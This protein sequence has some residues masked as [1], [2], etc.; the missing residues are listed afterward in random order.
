MRMA[1]GHLIRICRVANPTDLLPLFWTLNSSN[2]ELAAWGEFIGGIAVV[3]G[4]FFVGIQL[5][6]ANR[7][8]RLAANRTYAESIIGLGTLLNS[9][10]EIAEIWFKGIHGLD[11]LTPVET[12]RFFAL[13]SNN[14]LR[15]FENL[16]SHNQSGYLEDHIWN[17]AVTML[18]STL[19]YPGCKEA[20]ESRRTFFNPAYQ[21]FI[22]EIISNDSGKE[23]VTLYTVS[24][25]N[26]HDT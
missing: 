25:G 8:S 16:H 17:G 14:I 23:T 4:L 24:P 2:Q 15:T 9:N 22:D 12:A 7:E 5:R 26:V 20:W 10:E 13:F 19:I 21:A 3:A 6:I 1:S 11:K 18:Q